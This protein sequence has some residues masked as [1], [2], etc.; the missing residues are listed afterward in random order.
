MQQNVC[1]E[2]LNAGEKVCFLRVLMGILSFWSFAMNFWES[3]CFSSFFYWSLIVKMEL[4][5]CLVLKKY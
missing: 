3:L 4:S 1:N 2:L 5:V